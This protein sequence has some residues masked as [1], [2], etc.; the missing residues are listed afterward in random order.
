M[1]VTEEQPLAFKFH[2]MNESG[3]PAGFLRKKGR[4]DGRT[5]TLADAE[6]P[7][8]AILDASAR[9]ARI[10]ISVPTQDGQ[11]TGLGL[12]LTSKK[13][14]ERLKGALD[15]ARSA[16]WA[17]GHR[18]QLVEKGRGRSYRDAACPNCGATVVLSDMP[19]SPQ[20]YC[21]FC[22]TLSYPDRDDMPVVQLRDY[23]L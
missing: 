23:R 10:V 1:L 2:W 12:V 8:G 14:A 7:A 17:A 3:Q 15:I 18:Q 9:E 5:L 13:V 20:L 22:H 16:T 11:V 6:I 19:K 4:F 21:P